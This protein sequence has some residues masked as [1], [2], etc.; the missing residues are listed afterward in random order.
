MAALTRE[1]TRNLSA[2]LGRHGRP[3]SWPESTCVTMVDACLRAVRP[4]WGGSFR[5][6]AAL[7]AADPSRI[8][9][10]A[11]QR[12]GSVRSAWLAVIRE[13]GLVPAAGERLP[14]DVLLA[15]GGDLR[16]HGFAVDP[17]HLPLIGVYGPACEPTVRT[18]FG[19]WTV[20]E[21]AVTSVW[22]LP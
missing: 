15:D 8:W 20:D 13:A 3:E 5:L 4:D 10:A 9:E 7:A 11:E 16:V 18:P 17:E 1:R 2:A 14:G 19:L 6:P 12:H 21:S 22:R